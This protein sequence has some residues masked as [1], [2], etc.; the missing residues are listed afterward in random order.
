MS[1]SIY[2]TDINWHNIYLNVEFS[3]ESLDEYNFYIS[4]LRDEIFKINVQ[5]NKSIINIVN[6]EKTKLLKNG[7]WFFLAEKNEIYYFIGMTAS[8]GYKLEQLDKVYRYGR[9]IYAYIVTFKA[10]GQDG[11]INEY[12][13]SRKKIINIDIQTFS[14]NDLLCVINTSYMMKNKKNARRNILIESSKFTTLIKKM[15]FIV[16]KCV[17]NMIYHILAFFRKKDGK[18]ILLLSETRTPIGGNLKALD[19]RLKSRGLDQEYH[20]SYSFSKTLLICLIRNPIG[21]PRCSILI[22]SYLR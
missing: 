8:C 2:I 14:E 16:T 22:S 6:I 11:V 3:G 5:D 19:D 1:D 7:K 13:S 12:I 10:R 20:I 4:N 21:L 18:H 15:M 9:E 17:I